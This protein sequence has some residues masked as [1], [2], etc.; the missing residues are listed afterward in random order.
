M[1]EVTLSLFKV[2]S[3]L[4]DLI[5][6]GFMVVAVWKYKIISKLPKWLGNT[7]LGGMLLSGV[8]GLLWQMNK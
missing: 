4:G 6:W 1:S 3:N 2:L 8:F 5:F 7:L